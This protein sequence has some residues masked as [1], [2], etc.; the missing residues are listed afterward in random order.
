MNQ[1]KSRQ[2]C[3]N[4]HWKLI[5][6]WNIVSRVKMMLVSNIISCFAIILKMNTIYKFMW[7]RILLYFRFPGPVAFRAGYFFE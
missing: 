1:S 7:T 2:Q 6:L 3:I 4:Y 5:E